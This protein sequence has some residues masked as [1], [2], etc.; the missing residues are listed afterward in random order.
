VDIFHVSL[1]LTSLLYKH[2]FSFLMNGRLT[3]QLPNGTEK[4]AHLSSTSPVD[5]HQSVIACE[6]VPLARPTSTRALIV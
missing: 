4:L 5:A 3:F 1:V 2:L 6:N